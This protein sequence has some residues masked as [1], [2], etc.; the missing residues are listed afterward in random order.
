LG[1]T[2]PDDYEGAVRVE[3]AAPPERVW[4]EVFDHVA[5]PLSG[6]SVNEI[7]E[8]ANH[9]AAPAWEERMQRAMLTVET[10]VMQ[11]PT[12][13]ERVAIDRANGVEST[14]TYD[15]TPIEGGTLLRVRQHL[16]I[17]DPGFTTPYFRVFTHYL[18]FARQAPRDQVESILL[19]LDASDFEIL[20]A[21]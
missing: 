21:D 12:H 5:H 18:D 3:V 14:W 9:A 16:R 13:L 2:L 1:F 11:P 10:R 6:D 8:L 20:P 7:V 4:S 15:L 17:T 19:G